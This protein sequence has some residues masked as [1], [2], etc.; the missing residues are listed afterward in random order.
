[1]GEAPDSEPEE[2]L[3]TDLFTNMLTRPAPQ[4]A[5]I[6]PQTPPIASFGDPGTGSV[7]TLGIN[8]SRIE[9]VNRDG[10]ELNGE[11]RRLE[12][13]Q[14]T[15]ATSLP[16]LSDTQAERIAAS[17]RD[18]FTRRPYRQWFNQLDR[19]LTAAFGT[20]YYDSSACHLDLV[21][22]ATNPVWGRLRSEQRAIL[23]DEGRPHLEQ[24][25]DLPNLQTVVM[26]GGGVI[27][28]VR[29]AALVELGDTEVMPMGHT[30][31]RIVAGRRGDQQWVGWTTNLQSSVGVPN[32]FR[33]ALP[34]AV[35]R[36]LKS[37]W[38]A[39]T[40]Q[41]CLNGWTPSFSLTEQSTAH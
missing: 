32:S 27:K 26:N 24:L 19:V 39:D 38:L 25:L 2:I 10:A 17:Q 30:T 13:L 7:A 31:C 22:W 1:M 15:S 20:S 41:S 34:D 40:A 21:Q 6:V 16:N 11:D 33:E 4:H 3:K 37:L 14:S 12:T 23:L 36:A 18:Y 9:Y 5:S 28:E 8:P 35:T 29:R